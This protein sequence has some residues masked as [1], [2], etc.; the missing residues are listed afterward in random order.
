VG[1]NLVKRHIKGHGRMSCYRVAKTHRM[2]YL[3]DHFPQIKHIHRALLREMTYKDKA[4]YDSTPVLPTQSRT[5]L[6]LLGATMYVNI[7]VSSYP[8]QRE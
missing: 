6:P 2:P 4:S 5:W 7:Y 8:K 3:I 1:K